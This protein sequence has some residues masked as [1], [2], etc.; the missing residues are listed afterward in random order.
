MVG[1]WAM[2]KKRGEKFVADEARPSESETRSADAHKLNCNPRPPIHFVLYIVSKCWAQN[3]YLPSRR[4]KST[5]LAF[6]PRIVP[7][8]NHSH[9]DNKIRIRATIQN[10][11]DAKERANTLHSPSKHLDLVWYLSKHLF[12]SL[13]KLIVFQT[14][15]PE[16]FYFDPNA[17]WLNELSNP[18]ISTD[19]FTS[20][21][22]D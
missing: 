1:E 11:M 9:H 15:L 3:Y 7:Q 13:Q 14:N 5:R 21:K 20:N 4:R 22:L 17:N 18:P 6:N 19:Y 2:L 8:I 12:D 16:D 10:R